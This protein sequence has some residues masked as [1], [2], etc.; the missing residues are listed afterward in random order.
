MEGTEMESWQ[1]VVSFVDDAGQTYFEKTISTNQWWCDTLEQVSWLIYYGRDN[2]V[3][4]S[5]INIK[6]VPQE[7]LSGEN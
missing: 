7:Q 4:P 2:P 6:L 5:A 3:M 1:Y